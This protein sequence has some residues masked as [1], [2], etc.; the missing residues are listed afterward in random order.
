VKRAE[1]ANKRVVRDET[2]RSN[3]LIISN[4][5]DKAIQ[6]ITETESLLKSGGN[7]S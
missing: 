7:N 6:K 2:E 4:A 3:A 5:D 1:E